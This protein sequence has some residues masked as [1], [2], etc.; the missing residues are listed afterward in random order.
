[1]NGLAIN[2][3]GA[4]AV[5][6]TIALTVGLVVG[7][8]VGSPV[9]GLVVKPRNSVSTPPALWLKFVIFSFWCRPVELAL[10]VYL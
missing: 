8:V 3:A 10:S 4:L 7:L 6:L 5:A 1:M 9:S 2:L